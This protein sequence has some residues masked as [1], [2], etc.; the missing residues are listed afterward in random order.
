MGNIYIAFKKGFLP[1]VF[2]CCKWCG[3]AC[4]INISILQFE[5][6]IFC[7]DNICFIHW[8]D[9]PKSMY[10]IDSF[11]KPIYLIKQMYIMWLL[12]GWRRCTGLNK[13]L[14]VCVFE[15]QRF[16]LTVPS[17]T[18]KS[19]YFWQRFSPAYAFF[20]A[21]QGFNYIP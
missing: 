14:C 6:Q 7:D 4:N 2:H 21:A 10:S 11:I 5:K 9:I 13:I 12:W 19:H 1:M 17:S 3:K 15:V 8:E 20:S 16:S 18:D